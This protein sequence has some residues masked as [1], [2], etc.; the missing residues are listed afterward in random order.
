MTT[1]RRHRSVPR[2]ARVLPRRAA[3]T[4]TVR[5]RK[6][7]TLRVAYGTVVNPGVIAAPAT[8]AVAGN[9]LLPASITVSS[10]STARVGSVI[11]SGPSVDLPDGLV[12]KVARVSAGRAG[13]KVLGLQHVPVTS[14]V[15]VISYSGPLLDQRARTAAFGAYADLKVNGSDCGF[16][17]GFELGGSF[18]FGTPRI[19]ADVD[20]GN[21]G[22][23]ARA[24]LVIHSRPEANLKMVTAAGVF[25]EK[26]LAAPTVVVGYIPAGL[27]PVPVYVSVPMEMRAEA[28]AQ[29]TITSKVA[30]DMAVGVRTSGARAVP[31]FEARNPSMDINVASDSVT[32]VGPS[33]GLEIGL[34]VRS[35]ASINVKVATAV[36]FTTGGRQCS[37]DWTL[38]EFTGAVKVGPLSLRTPAAG[39][40]SHRLWTGC[41]AS[42]FAPPPPPPE[43]GPIPG[44]PFPFGYLGY[45]ETTNRV[46]P[47]IFRTGPSNCSPGFSGLVWSEWGPTRAVATGTVYYWDGTGS[48]L[49]TPAVVGPGTVV[50]SEP[51]TCGTAGLVFTKLVFT[52][53]AREETHPPGQCLP[54]A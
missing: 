44:L 54:P 6:T 15:P 20:A 13:T 2:G 50:L 35:A 47:E 51:K 10:R 29:T 22:F 9:P 41:G 37:W 45:G 23:G 16:T 36:E 8:L 48:C 42:T 3:F 17:G 21:F 39:V 49:T 4:V 34:G 19:E 12:A 27:I 33:V 5:T 32:T 26:T 46:R 7:T 52:T 53:P 25:C 28:T 1:L 18:T 11:L 24:N 30:W 14:A 40:G 38:G 31:V 43:A